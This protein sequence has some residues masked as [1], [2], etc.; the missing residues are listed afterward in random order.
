M[1]IINLCQMTNGNFCR[2]SSSLLEL[3]IYI[4]FLKFQ[5]K[6]LAGKKWFFGEI[7]RR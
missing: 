3:T 5:K 6:K 4:N 1:K 2:L 7:Q